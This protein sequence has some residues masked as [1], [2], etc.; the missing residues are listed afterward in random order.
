MADFPDR[1]NPVASLTALAG[2]DTLTDATLFERL[3]E[4][5]YEDLAGKPPVLRMKFRDPEGSFFDLDTLALGAQF[6]VSFGYNEDRLVRD[7]IIRYVEGFS[8]EHD[9]GGIELS[10]HPVVLD[11]LHTRAGPASSD[12]ALFESTRVTDAV[13]AVAR[14]VGFAGTSLVIEDNDTTIESIA[15]RQDETAAQFISRTAILLDYTWSVN[16]STLHFHSRR[17]RDLPVVRDLPLRGGDQVLSWRFEGD[18]R[19]PAPGRVTATGYNPRRREAEGFTATPEGDAPAGVGFTTP[20]VGP[21]QPSPPPRGAAQQALVATDQL[22]TSLPAAKARTR[23]Q[24]HLQ[25][26]ADRQWKLAMR[27]TGSPEIL[28]RRWINITDAPLWLAGAWYIRGVRHSF[29]VGGGYTTEISEATRR[30]PT[31]RRPHVEGYRAAGQGDEPAGVGHVTPV[32]V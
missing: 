16:N 3:L 28:A 20:T 27:L 15:F 22:P 13:R 11:R 12:V 31:A 5:T 17:F 30:V 29:S 18:L 24:A 14:S 25:A 19:I 32:Q 8:S 4:M 21:F 2:A 6:R 9:G 26:R 23:A 7:V 10:G 1:I